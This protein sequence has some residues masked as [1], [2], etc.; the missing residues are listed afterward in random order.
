M[1]NKKEIEE[2]L[3]QTF[4]HS[5]PQMVERYLSLSWATIAQNEYFT[6]ITKECYN[7]YVQGY[8]ISSIMVSQAINE[9][10]A[11]YWIEKNSHQPKQDEKKEDSVKILVETGI[12]PNEWQEAFQRI[13]GSFR[14]DYHHINP[15]IK[16]HPHKELAERNLKDLALLESEMFKYSL[17]NDGKIVPL[18]PQY[19]NIK[20]DGMIDAYINFE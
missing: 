19:W 18:Y 2:I 16:N 20:S 12:L 6:E 8:Y 4:E 10:F 3:R 13:Q 5:L 14:N 17:K 1:K 15:D 7:L 11:R 9:A